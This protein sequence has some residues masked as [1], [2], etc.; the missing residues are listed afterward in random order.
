LR[1][2]VADVF[3]PGHSRLGCKPAL[4]ASG[5]TIFRPE[6]VAADTLI[7]AVVK[8]AQRTAFVEV[9]MQAVFAHSFHV[10]PPLSCARTLGTTASRIAI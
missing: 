8:Q 3:I 7:G 4:V 10:T 5:V 2:V 9:K 6:V 1:G